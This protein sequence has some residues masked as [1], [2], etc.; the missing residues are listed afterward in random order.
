[1][2]VVEA[3]CDILLWQP[4]MTKTQETGVQLGVLFARYV[5]AQAQLVWAPSIAVCDNGA[6]Q[7]LLKIQ[8][9]PYCQD[10][11]R[12][13]RDWAAAVGPGYWQ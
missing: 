4:E 8:M 5:S 1:M 11:Q 12:E 13:P 10:S 9:Q 6:G 2:S 7:G 3:T